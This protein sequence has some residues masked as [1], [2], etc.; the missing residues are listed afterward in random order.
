MASESDRSRAKRIRR[1]IRDGKASPTERKWLTA[2]EE[3]RDKHAATKVD[4]AIDAQAAVE[5]ASTP[6]ATTGTPMATV[7]FPAEPQ[8]QGDDDDAD[9]KPLL[10]GNDLGTGSTRGEGA[11]GSSALP[12]QADSPT[13]I[14][15]PGLHAAIAPIAVCGNPDCPACTKLVGGSICQATG[16]VVWNAIDDETARGAAMMLL[17]LVG[18]I[19]SF[20]TKKPAVEPTKEEIAYMGQAIQKSTYRRINAIGAYDDLLM[21]GM[22]LGM[23]ANRARRGE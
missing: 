3:R 21:L 19:V 17:G 8:V 5:A 22:A 1:R 18:L 11:G 16:K 14:P 10:D 12:P 20:V 4:K 15:T 7:D 23:Y 2:Y 13:A 6:D 9:A